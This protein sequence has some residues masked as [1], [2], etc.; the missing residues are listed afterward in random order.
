MR[1]AHNAFDASQLLH[2]RG[3]STVKLVFYIHSPQTYCVRN[4]DIHTSRALCGSSLRVSLA[5]LANVALYKE[6]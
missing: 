3:Y 4:I 2:I 5:V 6:R 1:H